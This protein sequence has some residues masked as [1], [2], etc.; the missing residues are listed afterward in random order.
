MKLRIQHKNPFI[1]NKILKILE[2]NRLDLMRM[3]LKEEQVKER[4]SFQWKIRE[5]SSDF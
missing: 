1:L 3:C 4:L 5:I 2:L